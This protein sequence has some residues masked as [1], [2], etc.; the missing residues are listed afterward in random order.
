[1]CVRGDLCQEVGVG[2]YRSVV[3]VPYPLPR[4]HNAY[5]PERSTSTPDVDVKVGR[6]K[7]G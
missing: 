1:M 6:C 3:K 2:G 5:T 7:E 4:P